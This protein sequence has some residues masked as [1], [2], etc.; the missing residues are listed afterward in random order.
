MRV[1]TQLNNQLI[2]K[3]K[4]CIKVIHLD[5]IST[6]KFSKD[7]ESVMIDLWD[8]NA[9]NTEI[10][11]NYY[12]YNCTKNE[13][14]IIAQQDYDLILNSLIK[15]KNNTVHISTSSEK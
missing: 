1:K 7:R 15:Y 8:I 5:R 6:I 9:K 10:K 2:L 14:D 4:Y 12:N 11:Y 3:L 13:L